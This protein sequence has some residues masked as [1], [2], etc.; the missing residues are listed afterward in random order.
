MMQYVTDPDTH[1]ICP[2]GWHLP[3][4][5]DWC[6]LEQFVDATIVCWEEG[7]RGTDGGTKLKEGGSSGFEVLPAG[8]R[9]Q[10]GG[11]DFLNFTSSIWS[12]NVASGSEAWVR[13]FGVPF[14]QVGKRFIFKDFGLSVCCLKDN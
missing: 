10:E 3:D 6:E 14:A 8:F 11:F 13:S 9:Y 12:T 7:Y 2:E 5:A 4:E 1:G